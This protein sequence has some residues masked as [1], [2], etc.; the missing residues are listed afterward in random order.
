ME[1][2]QKI[3]LSPKKLEELQKQPIIE[4]NLFKSLD[5]KWF[6][7]KT[8]ITTIKPVAYLEKVMES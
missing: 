8:T 5:S 7:H 6:V 1:T 3:E 4:S 2:I